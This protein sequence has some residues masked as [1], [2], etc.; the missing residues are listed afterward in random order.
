M[1]DYNFAPFDGGCRFN[2]TSDSGERYDVVVLPGHCVVARPGEPAEVLRLSATAQKE[3]IRDRL[4]DS[5]CALPS[6][7]ICQNCLRDA[8]QWAVDQLDE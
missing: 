8:V 4:I 5:I 2:I 3:P 1:F 6:N 7:F